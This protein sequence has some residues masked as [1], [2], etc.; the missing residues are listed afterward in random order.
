[1]P[2]TASNK[3]TK[4]I[5]KESLFRQIGTTVNAYHSNYRILAKDCNDLAQFVPEGGTIP[6]YDAVNDFTPY[7]IETC[8]LA[9]FVKLDTD[10]VHDATFDVEKFLVSRLTKNFG[11]AETNAF[12]NGSGEQT[13]TGILHDSKGATVALSS[14]ALSYDDV[15][16]LYFSVKAEYRTKGVWLMNDTTAMV[17]RT[18]K[19]ADGNYL[20]HNNSDTILGK[21]VIISEFMPNIGVGSKPIAFGDFSYYWV[22][23]KKPVSVRTIKEKFVTLDQI[24]Y[25]AFEFLDGKLIRPEAIK[26]IQIEKEASK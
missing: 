14:S 22:I 9:A 19:D 3:Y 23:C 7:T 15:I 4:A 6:L 11:R 25:L 10:F 17:L 5:E 20:L 26:V 12:I 18:L 1:M 13:P 2:A 8:K 16:S 24:G 21:Q